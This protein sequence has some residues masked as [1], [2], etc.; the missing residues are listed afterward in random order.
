MKRFRDF[1]PTISSQPSIP[2]IV[3]AWGRMNPPTTGHEVL[4]KAIQKQA[5]LFHADA[6]IVLS[7]TVD[8]VRNPLPPESKLFY[9]KRVFPHI[10]IE[11]VSKTDPTIIGVMKEFEAQGYQHVI[12]VTGSDRQRQFQTLLNRYQGKE[13]RFD[14]IDV[15]SAGDRDPDA[16]DVRGMSASKA[17]EFAAQKNY[18]DFARS[19]PGND[20]HTKVGLMLAVRAGMKSV[21]ESTLQEGVN[22]AGIFKVVFLAGGP[23]SGKD[24]IL[25]K[26]L[27]GHG[28]VELNSDKALEF[29]LDKHKLS[30]LM[31]DSE[32]DQR[33]EIRKRAKSIAELRQRLAIEGRNGLIVNGT[34]DDADKIKKI[35]GYLEDQGYSSKMIFVNASNE[36]SKQRNEDRGKRGGRMVPEKIRKQKWD[37]SQAALQQYQDVFESDLVVVDNSTDAS[38]KDHTKNLNRIWKIMSH[39]TKQEVEDPAAKHWINTQTGKSVDPHEP[40]FGQKQVVDKHISHE[41]ASEAK[42]LG[43]VYYGFGRYGKNGHVTHKS[44]NGHLTELHPINVAATSA[45]GSGGVVKKPAMED[46]MHQHNQ[47]FSDIEERIEKGLGYE[48][49]RFKLDE[50]ALSHVLSNLE[51]NIEYYDAF[52]APIVET[53]FGYDDLGAPLM[54]QAPQDQWVQ[55]QTTSG[56]KPTLKELR[57]KNKNGQKRLTTEQ[58][59]WP[60]GAML[61][62]SALARGEVD[63]KW[64]DEAAKLIKDSITAPYVSTQISTLGGGAGPVFKRAAI[65]ITISLQPKNDWPN[66]I[67][68]N[69]TYGRFSLDSTGGLEMFS[70]H[71]RMKFR[72]TAVK[73]VEEA[74]KKL[75]NWVLVNK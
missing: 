31:P 59:S 13:Y 17:R 72:K 51:Q 63:Q 75:N 12:L 28:L 32:A 18:P 58:P 7:R 24:Y 4:V 29:L 68:E 62:I 30:K 22:D 19:I 14:R 37:S 6:K 47:T 53:T 55:G 56:T 42:A 20:S 69:S 54:G 65:L 38:D 34:G 1:P 41:A 66:G 39:F 48:L 35:K 73:T 40:E 70:G 36:I 2:T 8:P 64:L 9:A 50:E 15:V 33:N 52:P 11:L 74:I 44:L 10:G 46:F 49:Q 3:F 71:A 45:S 21:Q 26:T 25:K 16:D 57:K 67:L 60:S 5:D 61:R 43:L 23:G 27:D